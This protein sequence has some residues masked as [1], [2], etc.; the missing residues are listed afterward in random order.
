MTEFE[1]LLYAMPGMSFLHRSIAR[2]INHLLL[3]SKKPGQILLDVAMWASEWDMREED[4]WFCV[5]KLSGEKIW[6]V[7]H[8]GLSVPEL[9]SI[10]LSAA[11]KSIVRTRKKKMMAKV[12]TESRSDRVSEITLVD[13]SPSAISE[14]GGRIPREDREKALFDGYA[15]WLPCDK[16]PINGL[17]YKPD[18]GTLDK[19]KKSYPDICVDTMLIKMFEELKFSP[20]KPS[21]RSFPYWMNRWVKA[22][23]AEIS[24]SIDEVDT[25]DIELLAMSKQNE[26]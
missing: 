17:C 13:A 5:D 23:A 19:L 1:D 2:E 7:E 9:K 15:G 11:S 8:S 24:V 4:I 14:I 26:Y 3:K 22:N 21:L 16:F 10:A 12:D 25:M 6:L 20:H 18:K